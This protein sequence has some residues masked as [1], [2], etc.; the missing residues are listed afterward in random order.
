[1]DLAWCRFTYLAWY[2][3]DGAGVEETRLANY[4]RTCPGW[5]AGRARKIGKVVVG[6]AQAMME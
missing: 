6:N 2:V 3:I 4:V 1:M 5:P